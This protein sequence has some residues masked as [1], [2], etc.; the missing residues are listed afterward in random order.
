MSANPQ[1][2]I[3]VVGG[4]RVAPGAEI[5]ADVL[6]EAP[7]PWT[8]VYLE[9]YLEWHTEGKGNQRSGVIAKEEL[10]KKG[11]LAPARIE[12]RFKHRLPEMP[13]SYQGVALK[14]VWSAAVFAKAKGGG[15]VFADQMLEVRP[16]GADPSPPHTLVRAQPA[17]PDEPLP[18]AFR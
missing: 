13:W 3:S 8:V 17:V 11:E 12:R 18:E 9:Y 5:I 2:V 1:L 15:E 16:I 10:A 7:A 14:I 4:N 6:V